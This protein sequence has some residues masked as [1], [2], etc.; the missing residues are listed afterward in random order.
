M[1]DEAT[2]NLKARSIQ[3]VGSIDDKMFCAIDNALTLLEAKS[4][5]PIT[6]KISSDGGSVYAALAIVG[7]MQKSSCSINTEVYGRAMSAATIILVA[8]KKRRMSKLSWFMTHE[9]SYYLDGTHTQNKFN[10]QQQER[11]NKLWC[12]VMSEY[13]GA[14][15][16]FWETKGLN[17]MDLYLSA[18]QCL[19][20]KIIDEVF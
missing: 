13:S 2:L 5:R 4:K 9:G 19:K 6:F 1:S 10:V 3:L 14:S 8:G 18:N 12:Q 20:L 16:K 15:A 11:E 17:G 7:R